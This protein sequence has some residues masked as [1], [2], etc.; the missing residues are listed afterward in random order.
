MA[1]G[2]CSGMGYIMIK[3]RNVMLPVGVALMFSVLSACS[4]G[5]GFMGSSFKLDA[6]VFPDQRDLTTEQS[7]EISTDEDEVNNQTSA[8]RTQYFGGEQG[9]IGQSEIAFPRIERVEDEVKLNFIDTDVKIL[10]RAVFGDMLGLPYRID[11]SIQGNISLQTSYPISENSVLVALEVALQTKNIILYEE[12]GVY[13]LLPRNKVPTQIGLAGH[14]YDASLLAPGFT[15]NVVELK[16][17]TPSEMRKV[18]EPFAPQGGILVTD[19]SRQLLILAGSSRELAVMLNVVETFDVDW[20]QG[21]SFALYNVEYVEAEKLANELLQIFGDANSP[22]VGMVRLIPID[23]LNAILGISAQPKYL[24][25]VEAWIERLDIG[26][27]SPGRRI[28]VY[29]VNHGRAG[30]IASAL[31]SVMGNVLHGGGNQTGNQKPIQSTQNNSNRSTDVSVSQN[32]R[33]QP[34]V[35]ERGGLKIVPNE[36]NNSIMIL[37]SPSEFSV[38]SSA[39]VQIDI[40]PRQVLI[41]ATLVEVTLNDELKFGVQWFLQRDE[42]SA[43][44]SSSGAGGVASQFPGFSYVYDRSVNSRAVLNALASVTDVKVLSSPKLMVLNNQTATIQ[45]GD[46]V[47]VATQSSVSSTDSN[48]PLVNTVQFKDTGVIM[49]VTPR[50]GK[51]GAVLL[52]ISQEVS[53]VVPT[54]SSGIDSPTIQQRKITT[55]VVVQDGATVALGGLIHETESIVGSGIPF[56]KDIPLLGHAFSTNNRTTRRT[57][58]IIMITPQIAKDEEDTREILNYLRTQFRG[59]EGTFAGNSSDDTDVSQ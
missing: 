56:L 35:F 21:M 42:N 55:T 34:N 24:R 32:N 47:P 18:L 57:E 4:P 37:A 12:G 30:D 20:L 33:E 9:L 22:L 11:P 2:K 7:S 17:A 39:L 31:S 48:A 16:Y 50:I 26:G 19:D 53:D 8:E 52:D 41:E 15:I 36:E 6:G 5:P 3:S 1:W 40:A 13:V 43:T 27:S 38:I 46:Q 23:R 25:D 10:G 29:Q 14:S 44:L 59:L 28:Y 51:G 45:V 54:T 58:L 49:T